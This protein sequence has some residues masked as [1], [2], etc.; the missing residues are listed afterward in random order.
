MF[1]KFIKI[2]CSKLNIQILTN[3]Q[4]FVDWTWMVHKQKTHHYRNLSFKSNNWLNIPLYDYSFIT[5]CHFYDIQFSILEKA[6]FS[7]QLIL[8]TKNGFCTIFFFSKSSYRFFSVPFSFH[9]AMYIYFCVKRLICAYYVKF[10]WFSKV[11]NYTIG[12]CYFLR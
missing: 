10:K 12:K 11:Q 9:M 3:S 7:V 8:L 6:L 1:L 5:L 2:S 4:E